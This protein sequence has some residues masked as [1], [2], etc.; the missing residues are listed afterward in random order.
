MVCFRNAGDII[1][2]V[3]VSRQNKNVEEEAFRIFVKE[4]KIVKKHTEK[5]VCDHTIFLTNVW[6]TTTL[7]VT[8]L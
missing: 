6:D 5:T 2:R 4:V 3:Q 1:V 8:K 7:T